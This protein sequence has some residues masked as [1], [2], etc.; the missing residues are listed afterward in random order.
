MFGGVSYWGFLRLLTID[1]PIHPARPSALVQGTLAWLLDG[2]DSAPQDSQNRGA[3]TVL[4]KNMGSW[5]SVPSFYMKKLG[6]LC[7]D[8]VW[9]CLSFDVLIVK[10]LSWF[11]GFWIGHQNHLRPHLP[12]QKCLSP[13]LTFLPKV[14]V[15][16][17]VMT[18]KVYVTVCPRVIMGILILHPP[19]KKVCHWASTKAYFTGLLS[20]HNIYM[21][22]YIYTCVIVRLCDCAIVCVCV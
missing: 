12:I 7:W 11:K 9:F 13:G 16:V 14:Y 5:W 17:D 15:A 20:L 6:S 21:Y 3:P 4:N 19:G 2:W 10:S 18:G 1:V 22:I 8:F